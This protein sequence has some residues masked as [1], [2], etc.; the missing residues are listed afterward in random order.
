[1]DAGPLS[2]VDRKFVR[3][4]ARL[5][6]ASGL[7]IALHTGNNAAAVTEQLAL[8]DAEGVAPATWIWVHAHKVARAED[9]L[10]AARVSAWLGRVD[11]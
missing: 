5:H 10:P 6:L 1:M 4:A 11:I 2:D 3:T 8:L 9:L 7:T